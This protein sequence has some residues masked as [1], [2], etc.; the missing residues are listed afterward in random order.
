MNQ[1]VNSQPMSVG[2]WVKTLLL[3]MIP[4]A[5]IILM[6]VWAFGENV[7]ISKKNFF[8]AQLIISGVGLGISVLFSVII[9]I[10][11]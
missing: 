6:F 11:K 3:L 1:Q 5:N 9:Y 10:L 2:D 8:K 4:L 7:N